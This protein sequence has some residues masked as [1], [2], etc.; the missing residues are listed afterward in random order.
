L[1]EQLFRVDKWMIVWRRYEWPTS[2]ASKEKPQMRNGAL[3]GDMVL[4]W[5]L[6]I[7][8]STTAPNVSECYNGCTTKRNWPKKRSG[9]GGSGKV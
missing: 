6:G 4:V 1:S 5:G 2:F 9:K 8:P 3:V 7:V